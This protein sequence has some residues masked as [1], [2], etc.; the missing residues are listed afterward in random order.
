MQAPFTHAPVW[1]GLLLAQ[2][3]L[4]DAEA[5]PSW[6]VS[7]ALESTSTSCAAIAPVTFAFCSTSTVPFVARSS[8]TTCAWL[9]RSIA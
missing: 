7:A 8:P 4:H 9:W 1:H 3:V 6:K 2:D 5:K